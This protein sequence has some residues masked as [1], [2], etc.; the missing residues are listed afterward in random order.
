M[1][2]RGCL[3]V[4]VG[5]RESRGRLWPSPRVFLL[6]VSN[7]SLLV[8][9]REW[10]FH[11]RR[12]RDIPAGRRDG[13]R[14]DKTLNVDGAICIEALAVK[15][16]PDRLAPLG[17]VPQMVKGHDEAGGTVGAGDGSPSAWLRQHSDERFSNRMA[18]QMAV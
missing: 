8:S 13:R 1:A 6:R 3:D 2:V 17:C 9:V 15:S 7:S 11:S 18:F 12:Q 14:T 16:R 5:C 4:V 10:L